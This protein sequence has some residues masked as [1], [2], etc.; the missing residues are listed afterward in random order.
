MQAS[1]ID[2]LTAFVK[3][4]TGYLQIPCDI[5]VTPSEQG[6][7]AVTIR[8]EEHGK[9]LIGKGGQNLKALEHIVRAMWA[10]KNPTNHAIALDVNDYHAEQMQLFVT[11]VKNAADRVRE[12]RRSEALNPMSSYE[13]RIV[14]TE[15]AAYSD[16]TTESVGQ[17]PHRRVV[18][19]PL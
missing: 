6:P 14:H 13:R 8:S 16:L 18:I 2:T 4:L 15:L 17:D 9:L 5:T 11:A 3:E 1:D 12:T 19:K 7:I 10:R